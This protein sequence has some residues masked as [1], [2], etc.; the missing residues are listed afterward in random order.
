MGLK[1]EITVVDLNILF[2]KIK[3]L[4]AGRSRS[5]NVELVTRVAA[6]CKTVR[7]DQ[8][9]IYRVCANL[10]ANAMKASTQGGKVELEVIRHE[11]KFRIMVLDNGHGVPD[12]EKLKIFEKYETTRRKEATLETGTGIDL[13]FCRAAAKALPGRLWV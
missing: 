5:L 11:D 7:T 13:A 6:N 4:F 9:L 3:K 2:E 1:T 8:N 10:I 12:S